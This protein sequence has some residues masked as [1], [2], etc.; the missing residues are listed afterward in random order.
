MLSQMCVAGTAALFKWSSS[1]LNDGVL[2]TSSPMPSSSIPPSSPLPRLLVYGR[3]E[4]EGGLEVLYCIDSLWSCFRHG[5]LWDDAV[6][7]E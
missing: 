2:C 6:A 3:E 5:K 7:L 4:E 1:F